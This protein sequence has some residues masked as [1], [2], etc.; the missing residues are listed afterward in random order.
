MTTETKLKK[1]VCPLMSDGTSK[2]HCIE[3][4][5][6][7]WT[8]VYTTERHTTYGCIKVLEPQMVDGLLRV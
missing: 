4:E 1:K 7:F 3:H 8:M 5:C 2:I 6:M